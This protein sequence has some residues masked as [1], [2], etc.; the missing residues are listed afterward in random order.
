MHEAILASRLNQERLHTLLNASAEM[1][2]AVQASRVNQERLQRSLQEQSQQIEELNEKGEKVNVDSNH[3]QGISSPIQKLLTNYTNL[4]EDS[5]KNLFQLALM[6]NNEPLQRALIELQQTQG[7]NSHY[8]QA[9]LAKELIKLAQT[10]KVAELTFDN[11][12]TKRR[13][14]YFLWSTKLRPILAMFS[15][16]SKVLNS[17]NVVPFDDADCVGN[18]ALYLLVSATV[19]EYFQRAIKQFEGYGDKALAF[20]KTQCADISPE[21]TYHYHH[22]FTTLRIKDNESATYFFK[23]FTFAQTEA[24]AAGNTYSENQLVSYALAGFT[25]THN[26]RYE[27]AL[28]LYRLEREQDPS[29]FTLAQLEKKFFSMD[30]QTARDS[31]LTKIAHGHAAS[32]HRLIN[33][34]PKRGKFN[35]HKRHIQHKGKQHIR[36]AKDRS[37]EANATG[38]RI[39]CYYCNEPGHIAPNCPK[40]KGIKDTKRQSANTTLSNEIACA[41][42]TRHTGDLT[43]N[44][45]T[46]HKDD[47]LTLFLM[48]EV[49]VTIYFDAWEYYEEPRVSYADI[50]AYVH[51]HPL[52]EEFAVI[53][54]LNLFLDTQ[55]IIKENK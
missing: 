15:Q 7:N 11:K 49:Y 12:A 54:N 6:S 8:S 22:V 47:G 43:N 13:T 4:D 40:K 1:R 2:Q 32:G 5:R 39:V 25:S 48:N 19:D 20:I 21:D 36:S 55:E 14:N 37:A 51:S 24:E 9:K 26:H 17:A 30:E 46:L 31:M 16:T 41:A 52:S 42:I 50:E 33:H 10:Y 44:G 35:S 29:K 38:K 23:R 34:Q 28:Q 45:T 18:K 3:R 27:T 53:L